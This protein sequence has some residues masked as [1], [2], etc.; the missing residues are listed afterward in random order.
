MHFAM[1]KA[2][3]FSKN[4]LQHLK[5]GKYML[6]SGVVTYYTRYGRVNMSQQECNAAM[7]RQHG[8]ILCGKFPE[9]SIKITAVLNA[10]RP[11]MHESKILFEFVWKF[12]ISRFHSFYQMWQKDINQH[13]PVQIPLFCCRAET[14]RRPKYFFISTLAL[15]VP[16]A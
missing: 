7:V 4:V 12:M 6:L 11:F 5:H 1:L 8:M 10:A 3:R 2:I 13:C 14:F 15:L 9:V 16:V